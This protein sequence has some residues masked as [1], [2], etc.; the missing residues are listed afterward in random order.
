MLRHHLP[1]AIYRVGRID[2]GTEGCCPRWVF[3][4]MDLGEVVGCL[5]PHGTH[6]C[7]DETANTMLLHRLSRRTS[8]PHRRCNTT[9]R[10]L[11]Y[12]ENIRVRANS[13]RAQLH[14]L[15]HCTTRPGGAPMHDPKKGNLAKTQLG[16][17]SGGAVGGDTW[18]FRQKKGRSRGSRSWLIRSPWID[19]HL[20]AELQ[21]CS[22]ILATPSNFALPRSG[23]ISC[24]PTGMPLLVAS[25]GRP[26]VALTSGSTCSMRANA[27]DNTSHRDTSRFFEQSDHLVGLEA[28]Q[29]QTGERGSPHR[30]D[31][32]WSCRHR[33]STVANDEAAPQQCKFIHAQQGESR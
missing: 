24:S 6:H 20:G 14:V 29:G 16:R 2:Q 11:T 26:V 15:H 13:H 31:A 5:Q 18:R 25:A 19:R 7:K 8:V 30:G 22:M 21:A 3:S 33:S 1:I 27:A 17:P 4:T 32:L 10:I 28:A 12:P 23:P 9:Q